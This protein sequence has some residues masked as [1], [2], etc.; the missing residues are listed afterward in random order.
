M[1]DVAVSQRLLL[2]GNEAVA[3]GAWEAGCTFGS[4]YP[5]TPS[6]EILPALLDLRARRGGNVYCEWSV[7]EKVALEAA[8]GACM[9]RARCLV[10]MKHVGLN[11]AAD[12][13][14]TLAYT[15]VEGAVVIVSA[16][17]PGLHSS[18]N[19]QDNRFFA[20]HAGV[21]MLEPADSQEAYDFARLAFRL[22]EEFDTPVLLRLTTRVS[23][24]RSPVVS[25]GERTE[26]E[27][28]A[29]PKSWAKYVMVP[30][31]AR[32]RHEVML[33][34]LE[35]LSV[36]AESAPVNRLDP[37]EGDVAFVS[38][39]IAYQYLREVMPSAPVLKLGMTYPLP[40][41]LVHASAAGR[42]LIAV[43]ELEPY[44]AEQLAFLGY[45]VESLPP[46]L[47]LGELTPARLAS[48]L[49]RM[50]VPV[51][52]A[53]AAPPEPLPDLPSRP[54][55]LCPGCSHRPVF[56]VLKRMG[57]LVTGDIGCY[58]LG[59]LPP[60]S[61]LHTCLCMG[62][63][64]SQA[65]GISRALDGRQ[66]VVAVIGDST[67]AHAGLPALANMV[68]NRSN[69]VVLILDNRTTAMTGGQDHPGTGRTLMGEDTRAMDFIA[70]A[71]AMGVEFAR[72]VNAFDIKSVRATIEE[73][74]AHDGPAVVVTEGPCAL[75]YRI[76][77]DP[78]EV[79]EQTCTACGLCLQLGCPAIQGEEREGKVWPL[80]DTLLCTGCGLCAEVCSRDAIHVLPSS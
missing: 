28:V 55:V 15:G 65:H 44:L 53:P 11:V 47:R 57:L 18:Q 59:A 23:H 4:G 10:T 3:L 27:V 61:S 9:T 24:S 49:A 43:E 1:S 34:R 7:N 72:R 25:S 8:S 39:G 80:I 13:F 14:F 30:A 45:V 76:R 69:A 74:L 78:Y 75:L 67:F 33:D 62:A 56:H 29:A 71:Q 6:S 79:D 73:A 58:T 54:P 64:V 22:S 37:G 60:L 19:E 46:D 35:R 41:G 38:A 12:P 36:W 20:R 70:V 31:N 26:P 16:D 42:R 48:A 5:G 66:P 51:A 52:H 17:D 2:S 63:G 40:E 50:D 68:Y 77:S 32:T 21:P